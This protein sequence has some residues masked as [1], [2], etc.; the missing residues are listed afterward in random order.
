MHEAS[1][2]LEGNV[3]AKVAFVF[4]L[5][6]SS[7]IWA[8]EASRA[9]THERVY[10]S[11]YPPDGE[12][13]RRLSFLDVIEYRSDDVIKMKFVKLWDLL[14]Y[15]ERTTSK[16]PTRQKLAIRGK[17]SSKSYLVPNIINRAKFRRICVESSQHNW[18]NI[19]ETICPELLIFGK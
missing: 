17:L 10:F 14:R 16:T 13:A 8:S 15:S 12:L 18:A 11:Q 2:S 6:A 9:R 19:S 1:V 3:Q 5:R 7:S 4:S